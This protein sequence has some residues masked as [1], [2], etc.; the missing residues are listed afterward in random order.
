MEGAPVSRQTY[1]PEK[2]IQQL[3]LLSDAQLSSMVFTLGTNKT[4]E[5][6]GALL[7]AMRIKS[8]VA[9][10]AWRVVADAEA[11]GIKPESWDGLK[12]ALTLYSPGNFVPEATV[13]EHICL[14]LEELYDYLSEW[15]TAGFTTMILMEALFRRIEEA[16]AKLPRVL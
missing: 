6:L 7:R 9:N 13:L 8:M 10:A 1:L 11:G 5:L 15:N 2:E 3:E 16:R 4:A 14:T 12:K